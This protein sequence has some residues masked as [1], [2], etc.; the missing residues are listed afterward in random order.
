MSEGIIWPDQTSEAFKDEV[1]RKS[2]P[3]I[4]ARV[5]PTQ[6]KVLINRILRPFSMVFWLAG[7][8]APRVEG[9]TASLQLKSDAQPRIQQPYKLSAFDQKRLEYHEDMEVADQPMSAPPPNVDITKLNKSRPVI[10]EAR[11]TILGNNCNP[12]LPLWD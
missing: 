6:R 1:V 9:Y 11:P 12:S 8:N 10:L 2:E 5:S 4:D 7:C 3:L